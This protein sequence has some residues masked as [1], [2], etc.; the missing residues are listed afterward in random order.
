[1]W[2]LSYV[3][4]P[5]WHLGY[6]NQALARSHEASTLAQ[7]LSHPLSLAA[8]LDYAA[9]VHQYRRERH[10]TQERAEAGIALS[11][12]KGFPQF[13]ALGMIMRG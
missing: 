6:P 5:L 2:C 10:A 12:E 11:R 8:A 4:W 3:A 9:F 7:E 1:V 13:V